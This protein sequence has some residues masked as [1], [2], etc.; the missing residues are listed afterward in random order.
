MTGPLRIVVHGAPRTKKTHN[1]LV[2]A[3]RR[4]RV[5]PSAQ[6]EAWLKAAAVEIEGMGLAFYGTLNLQPR[7]SGRFNCAALFYRDADRGDAVGYY[8]GV[9][10]LLEK[11]G[12]LANDKHIVSWD[13][14]RLLKDAA[15]PRVELILTPV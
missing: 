10:D 15:R 11:R 14:S 9:A 2:T 6:W 12:I 1:R 8:Q 13:G 7:L 4:Q 5:L 3:G